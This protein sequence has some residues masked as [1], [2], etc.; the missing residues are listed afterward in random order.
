MADFIALNILWLQENNCWAMILKSA[1][2]RGLVTVRTLKIISN[3]M[4]SRIYGTNPHFNPWNI[5]ITRLTREVF[6]TDTLQFKSRCFNW[7]RLL[8]W[9]P[10]LLDA[11]QSSPTGSKRE[12]WS[13]HS[14]FL[15]PILPWLPPCFNI[16]LPSTNH[17]KGMWS[18]GYL[19]Q[20]SQLKTALK[21][22]NVSCVHK[23]VFWTI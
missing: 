16:S 12:P 22:N 5:I 23:Y 17:A 4:I 10:I 2:A 9:Q 15:T 8:T 13:Y 18:S 11:C 19:I 20:H 21:A 1:L 3:P 6:T 7:S 14:S